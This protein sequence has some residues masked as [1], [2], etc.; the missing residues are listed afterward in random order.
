MQGNDHTRI[1]LDELEETISD[2]GE[3]AEAASSDTEDRIVVTNAEDPLPEPEMPFYEEGENGSAKEEWN[4]RNKLARSYLY[5]SE[6]IP[7]DFAEAMR[8]FSLE[9]DSGNELPCMTKAGCGQTALGWRRIR[10]RHRNGTGKKKDVPAVP[11][12][13]DQLKRNC[14]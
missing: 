1:R 4:K 3:E 5:G 7:Q 6:R 8:L 13:E 12:R 14:S 9:A 2:E 11:D 10:I